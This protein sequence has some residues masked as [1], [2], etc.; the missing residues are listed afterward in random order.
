MVDSCLD[1]MIV[2]DMVKENPRLIKLV[3]EAELSNTY[4]WLMH[5]VQFLKLSIRICTAGHYNDMM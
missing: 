5:L 3:D 1:H 4:S 2:S